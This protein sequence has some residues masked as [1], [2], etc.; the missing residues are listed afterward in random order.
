MASAIE[1]IFSGLLFDALRFRQMS[2]KYGPFGVRI[3]FS[4]QFSPHS[5]LVD[6]ARCLFTCKVL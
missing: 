6:S 2:S 5:R 1:S 3:A 4:P